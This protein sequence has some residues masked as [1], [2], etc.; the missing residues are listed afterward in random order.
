MSQT[1]YSQRMAIGFAGMIA[2]GWPGLF[3][4]VRNSEASAEMAFGRAVCWEPS[5][6]DDQDVLLPAAESDLVR[7]IVVHSHDYAKPSQLGDTGIKAGQLLNIMRKGRILAVCEDGCNPGDRLWVRAVAAG[8]PEF[9]GGLNSADDSTDMIDCTKQ[10]Q[11][12]TTAAAGGLAWLE[13]DFT[14]KP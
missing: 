11:W 5:S 8:D 7:G 1:S 9:L 14:A 3:D 6:T 13:V 2:D 12:L 4:T 10:G